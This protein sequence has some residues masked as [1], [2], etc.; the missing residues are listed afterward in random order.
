MSLDTQ[1]QAQLHTA[2]QD[3]LNKSELFIKNFLANVSSVD[4]YQINSCPTCGNV[5]AA[6]LFQK[7][8]GDYAYCT[9]CTHI[10]LK[11][12]LVPE[13]LIQFY[14]EYPTS[15]LDWH[16]NESE[17]YQNIYNHGLDGLQNY[18]QSGNLLDVG[19]SSGYFLSIAQQRGFATYGVE[20]NQLEADYAMH[21]NINV[22]GKTI[23]ESQLI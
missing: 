19:C 14:T 12:S 6:V 3:Q 8:G 16:K 13:K 22:L 23:D 7:N 15:S 10:F 17:F 20:P 4:N 1:N 5:K 18:F 21:N 2:R 9:K 11:K